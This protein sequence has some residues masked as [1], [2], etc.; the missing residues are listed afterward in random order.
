MSDTQSEKTHQPRPG[1]A[2]EELR[3]GPT[4]I[5]KQAA[6][7]KQQ[8]RRRAG[9]EKQQAIEGGG[10]HAGMGMRTT[11]A[12]GEQQSGVE[13]SK[14]EMASGGDELS[15]RITHESGGVQ[16]A[17]AGAQQQLAI[18]DVSGQPALQLSREEAKQHDVAWLKQQLC[19][20]KRLSLERGEE[21]VVWS[22]WP[23]FMQENQSLANLAGERQHTAAHKLPSRAQLEPYSA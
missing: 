5:A 8:Q 10:M 19:D 22:Q 15:T 3:A 9:E 6:E 18:L 20:S 13:W 21:L 23:H 1:A 4:H 12:G 7:Q 14:E 11:A 2:T 17:T 16:H